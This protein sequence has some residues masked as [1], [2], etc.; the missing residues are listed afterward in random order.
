[1]NILTAEKI[2]KFYRI[3][4]REIA[5]LNT[6]SLAVTKGEFLVVEGRSGSG[7]TTLLSLLSGLDKPTAG[8]IIFDDRDITHVQEDDLAPLRNTMFGFVFQSFHLVPAL[9][10]LENVM[11]PAEI[12]RDPHAEER[13]KSLLQRVGLS[14]RYFNY[15]HQL[16]GG[17][18]Q[19][20]AI[21]RAVINHPQIIF[22]DE[23]TGNLDSE[24]GQTIIEL[25]LEFHREER[26][27]LIMA[28]HNKDIS[29]LADRII[30]LTDGRINGD[31]PEAEA[32]IYAA[33]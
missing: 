16:S 24:N 4:D 33:Q 23:P 32:P 7:K 29:S 19:R 11:F 28:T 17:E 14:H 22:A 10:A 9:T 27:T 12:K 1:M 8:R 5:V 21:C 2:S 15:P 31:Q 30:R 13:A 20:V 18:M 6:I 25:L 26:T 3:E